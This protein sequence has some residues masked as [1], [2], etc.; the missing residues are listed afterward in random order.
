MLMCDRSVL[1]LWIVITVLRTTTTR[2]R[3]LFLQV[4][5]YCMYC[6]CSYSIYVTFINI[7][8][9][10]IIKFAVVVANLQ[11]PLG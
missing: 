5:T 3:H 10:R 4:D 2:R 1:H 7:Y 11:H 8:T 9:L 6:S